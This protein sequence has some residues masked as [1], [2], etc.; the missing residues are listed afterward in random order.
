MIG[1]VFLFNFRSAVK[2]ISRWFQRGHIPTATWSVSELVPRELSEG[3]SYALGSP[4]GSRRQLCGIEHW[5]LSFSVRKPRECSL[6]K[7]KLTTVTLSSNNDDNRVLWR[8]SA[9]RR[10]RDIW[11]WNGCWKQIDDISWTWGKR[12]WITHKEVFTRLRTLPQWGAADAEIKVT[13][14]ENTEF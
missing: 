11:A 1:R 14:V 3:R 4:K 10:I 8:K 13:S 7:C 6:T 5:R 12:S 2:V 9:Q